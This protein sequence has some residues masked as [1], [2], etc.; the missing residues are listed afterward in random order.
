MKGKK[1]KAN[2][3]EKKIFF[4]FFMLRGL[5]TVLVRRKKMLILAFSFLWLTGQRV[6]L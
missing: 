3:T 1:L 6:I 4:H 2:F 5:E